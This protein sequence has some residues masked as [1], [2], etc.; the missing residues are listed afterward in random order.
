MK[1]LAFGE[2]LWDVYPDK[3]YIGGAPLNFAGHLARHKD[4]VYLLSAVGN[5]ELGDEALA[6]LKKWNISADHVTILAG[7]PTGKCVVTLDESGI[8]SYD[9]WDGVAYDSICCEDIP[10]DFG[11]LYF[12]TLS[13]RSKHNF[14]ELQKLLDSHSFREIFVDMNI[15]PP[16]YSAET[17]RFAA[18]N[19]TILKISDEELPVVA[20]LLELE[21]GLHYSVFIE[22]LACKYENLRCIIITRGEDGACAYNCTDKLH[23]SCNSRKVKV[24]STVGAG[25]SFSAAFLHRYLKGHFMQ[26]CLEHAADIAAFVVSEYAAVPKYFVL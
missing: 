4:D 17:V 15:R 9:L 8:P 22:K 18:K 25:D 7:I 13:L 14:S 5:D 24:R 19:A 1:I 11:V 10:D 20:E 2:I 6:V 3:R 26:H 23:Y 12:G 16:H 21:S